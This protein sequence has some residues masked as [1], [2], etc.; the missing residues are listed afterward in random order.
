MERKKQTN[1][2]RT[3]GLKKEQNRI[4]KKIK[5]LSKQKSAETSNLEFKLQAEI[6]L[7]RQP[8]LDLEV[9]R[10]AKM[11]VFR[12]ETERLLKQEKPVA[13]GLYGAMKQ[14][15]ESTQNLRRWALETNS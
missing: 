7:A 11:L 6:K 2:K 8:L 10:D 13:E 14:R 4:E 9:A 5:N 1:Q 12:Q 3:D 15:K